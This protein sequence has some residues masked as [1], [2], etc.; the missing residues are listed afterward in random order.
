[1][2]ER[3]ATAPRA[4]PWVG[5]PVLIAG[6]GLA[7]AV[8]YNEP[9]M[10]SENATASTDRLREA[11]A[12]ASRAELLELAAVVA[13]RDAPN[14]EWE[15]RSEAELRR[16][17][18]EDLRYQG[19]SNLAFVWR[20][21]TRGPE[22]A[23]VAYSEIVDDLVQATNLNRAL[24][25]RLGDQLGDPLYAKEFLFSLLFTL[26]SPESA[27]PDGAGGKGRTDVLKSGLAA[28]KATGFAPY[29]RIVK[30]GATLARAAAGKGLSLALRAGPLKSISLLLGPVGT[31]LF[32]LDLG[33]TAYALQ[34][35]NVGRCALAVAAVGALRLKYAPLPPEKLEGVERLIESLGKE[36]LECG[37]PL[38]KPEDACIVCW[39]G[40][41][42][43]CG[44]SV[45]RLDTG[46]SG[47]VCSN[48][49]QRDLEGAGLLVPEP[50]APLVSGEWV[51]ALGYRAQVLNNRLDRAAREI[52][53]S[54]Q[55]LNDN[56]QQLRKDVT[57]DLRKIVR[58]A[59]GYLYVMFFTT[60][61]LT[62]F[63]IAYF[64]AAG[65]APSGTFNPGSIFRLSGMVM[66]G[67]PL[68]VWFLG[69]LWRA[70]R[71]ARRED[72]EARPDGRRLG[73]KDYLFGFLY[74]ENPIENIWGPITLIGLTLLVLMWL[75]LG[76]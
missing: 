63:G 2:E 50:G 58:S 3:P 32:V 76:S 66:V 39:V 7:G 54:I 14:P 73:F 48:C 20:K 70:A 29:E 68:A 5:K 44:S 25:K 22:A 9:M 51:K 12:P 43:K 31:G 41:H 30:V 72:F 56:A 45:E 21:I 35:P 64:K 60:V 10:A 75:F 42:E 27:G 71:N 28:L 16:Q 26:A 38:E 59:F 37:K 34:G 74:Y 11:L 69:A 53:A 36:C 4:D 55:S 62:L 40:L 46:S 49:R 33:R 57:G 6:N 19:S 23:G 8:G 61:F 18:E 13:G 1:M 65:A 52:D 24:V 17:I 15:G 67:V 47:R